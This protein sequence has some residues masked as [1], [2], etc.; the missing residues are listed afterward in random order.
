MLG[1]ARKELESRTWQSIT[2]PDDVE[3]DAAGAK[4]LLGDPTRE[5]YTIT[6]R[7]I[8]KRGEVLWVNHH[9]RAVWEAG[10]FIAFFV[11]AIPVSAVEP[12]VSATKPFSFTEWA[13]KNPKDSLIIGLSATLFLGRE[14]M[15][16]LLKTWI[17]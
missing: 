14:A 4:E 1:Y 3:G 8:T 9:V 10:K 7:Y 5:V 13:R 17:K 12:I 15:I 11:I 2:H 6:K 16:E